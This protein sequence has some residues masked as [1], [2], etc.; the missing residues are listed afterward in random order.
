MQNQIVREKHEKNFMHSAIKAAK[1]AMAKG[2]VPV[3]AV[4]VNHKDGT[5]IARSGNKSYQ[6]SNPILHAEILVIQTA[7][8]KLNSLYLENCDI[9]VTLEPCAMCASALSLARINRIYYGAYDFKSGGVDNG[10]MV[11][12]A[13]SCH[14]KPEVYGGIMEAE[15][16]SLLQEFFQNRR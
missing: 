3:G 10:A 7:L 2:E 14:H 12:N 4:I 13:S 9:Y 6:K 8:K 11:F 1:Q 5:I 16:K 15:C